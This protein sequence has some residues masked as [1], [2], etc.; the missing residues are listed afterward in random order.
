MRRPAASAVR[1]QPRSYRQHWKPVRALPLGPLLPSPWA[2]S[3]PQKPGY[4]LPGATSPTWPR[5]YASPTKTR[6]LS[7]PS[8]YGLSSM[9]PPPGVGPGLSA[10]A[11]SGVAHT[12]LKPPPSRVQPWQAPRQTS[13]SSTA[14]SN[15]WTHR[16]ATQ[17]GQKQRMF[18]PHHLPTP[19]T[20]DE[21]LN[22]QPCG[23]RMWWAVLQEGGR[24]S[25]L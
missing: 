7:C 19:T 1:T 22:W 16:L 14:P 25:K 17:V 18:Q 9:E 24:G 20:Y 3:R 4:N 23:P 11:T 6:N 10:E 15:P 8:L 2:H 21:P 5:P 12:T 13:P